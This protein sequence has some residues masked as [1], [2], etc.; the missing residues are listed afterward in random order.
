M[1][2]HRIAV[3]AGDG[4]GPE[5]V[6]EARTVVDATGAAIEWSELPWG[7]AYY[8][9][10]GYVVIRGLA[11]D[12]ACDAAR[13]AYEREVKSYP[14]FLYRQATANPEKH[15]LTTHGHVLNSLLNIQDFD[16]R[17]FPHALEECVTI[18][19]HTRR[20][21]AKSQ[22]DQSVYKRVTNWLRA[23]RPCRPC[24]ELRHRN[25]HRRGVEN[26]KKHSR[27]VATA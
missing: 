15:V 23:I 20:E 27:R 25:C 22:F 6:A 4:I 16:A 13:A 2:V 12:A 7:S 24:S 26:D 19:V 17:R 8:E 3:I 5:V 1:A 11:S 10:H 14:G 18:V 9:E 21:W